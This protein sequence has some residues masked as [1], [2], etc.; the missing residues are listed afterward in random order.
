MAAPL[1]GAPEAAATCLFFF[2]GNRWPFEGARVAT[3][4]PDAK[5][6][7]EQREWAR[8]GCIEVVRNERRG[9]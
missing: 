7:N 6:C 9:F 4:R 8:E 3:M 5:S 2:V 1:V